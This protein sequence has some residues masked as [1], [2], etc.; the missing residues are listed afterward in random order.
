M[1][2]EAEMAK[3]EK[4]MDGRKDEAGSME[5]DSGG[6]CPINKAIETKLQR[7]RGLELV[8]KSG[9]FHCPIGEWIEI[10]GEDER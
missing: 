1:Q 3:R 5:L 9:D 6:S 7:Y 8:K 4:C 10:H 2:L